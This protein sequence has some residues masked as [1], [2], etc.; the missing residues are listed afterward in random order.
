MTLTTGPACAWTATADSWLTLKSST[1]VGPASIEVRAAS[2]P[3][4]SSRSG[5]VQ[6]A[7]REVRITQAGAACTVALD[8][9]TENVGVNGT[10]GPSRFQV[11]VADGCRWT[12]TTQ[13]KEWVSILSATG[14]GPGV[15]SFTVPGNTGGAR[16]ADI[17]VA[18]GNSAATFRVTQAACSYKVTWENRDY[19]R[20]G[21]FEGDIDVQASEGSLDVTV[22]TTGT[23]TWESSSKEPWVSSKPGGLQT[24][25][26]SFALHF[27]TN[28]TRGE[29]KA[30]V[31]IGTSVATIV[32]TSQVLQ[33]QQ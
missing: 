29:R 20:Q 26:R 17:L 22:S 14:T 1:G 19:K 32:Q 16:K 2:N 9:A 5:S 18:A 30:P 6:V 25:T 15:V 4:A 23:C 31:T 24:G 11:K 7:G 12:A 21:T 10:S 28:D 13:Q 33:G 8:P 27:S 3:N